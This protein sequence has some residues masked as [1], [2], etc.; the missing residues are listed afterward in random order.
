MIFYPIAFDE[1]LLCG[2]GDGAVFVSL[3][4]CNG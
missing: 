3:I 2:S 1:F 4:F